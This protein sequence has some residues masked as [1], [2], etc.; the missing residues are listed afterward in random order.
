MNEFLLSIKN[1][2]RN[3]FAILHEKYY[4][5]L[6]NFCFKYLHDRD[7]AEEIVQETF[8]A[9]WENRGRIDP[10]LSIASYLISIARN[11]I[12]DAI[13]RKFTAI[14]HREGVR[15]SFRDALTGDEESLWNEIIAIMLRS[16]EHLPPR[17]REILT[18]RSQ[19]YS[20]S[21]ISAM[22]RISQRTV[23][24]HFSRAIAN[25]RS[26]MGPESVTLS[27]FLWALLSK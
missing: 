23:E 26:I 16:M 21:E 14:R 15:K 17:Q 4:D 18:L 13:K 27:V 10:R 2:D 11:K 7:D 19:G 9:I 6:F 8:I 3:A 24:T 12:F 5:H 22:L 25:L 1:G 20:N